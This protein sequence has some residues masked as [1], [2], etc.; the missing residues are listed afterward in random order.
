MELKAQRDLLSN[1]ITDVENRIIKHL[2]SRDEGSKTH[3]EGNYKVTITAKINRVLDTN[4]WESVKSALPLH[5]HPVKYKPTLDIKGVRYLQE[6]EPDAYKQVAQ[7]IT[8]KP[9]KLVVKVVEVE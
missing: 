5:L 4:L 2:G 8:A 3:N 1:Q 6:N 7:A 9:G